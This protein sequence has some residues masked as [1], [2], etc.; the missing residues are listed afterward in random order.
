MLLEPANA[1]QMRQGKSDIKLTVITNV[2]EIV[3]LIYLTYEFLDV[4]YMAFARQIYA[5]N[6]T[7]R[8]YRGENFMRQRNKIRRAQMLPVSICGISR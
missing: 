1:L 3:K 4:I 8:T 7:V 6:S 5:E 2:G